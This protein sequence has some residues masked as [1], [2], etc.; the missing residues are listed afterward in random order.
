MEELMNEVAE[1]LTK[2]YNEANGTNFKT[3][4]EVLSHQHT[5]QMKTYGEMLLKLHELT[6][7]KRKEK[8]NTILENSKAV[9]EDFKRVGHVT[10][11][12]EI[13]YN[14]WLLINKM[15][16]HP[17][18]IEAGITPEEICEIPAKYKSTNETSYKF[19]EEELDLL[20]EIEN[21]LCKRSKQIWG[22]THKKKIKGG[23]D[24]TPYET[25][26]DKL[27]DYMELVARILG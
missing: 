17:A 1:E 5:K 24:I 21:I 4:A 7:E 14:E 25:G 11:G 2:T 8:R 12:G 23:G 27:Y 26:H 10:W 9:Y 15:I 22:M 18:V 6:E 19:T 16:N 20:I 3:F 13:I